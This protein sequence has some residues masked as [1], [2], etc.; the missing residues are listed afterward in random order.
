MEINLLPQVNFSGRSGLS[1]SLGARFTET[2]FVYIFMALA[3]CSG[4][5]SLM[6]VFL[7][8]LKL[9]FKS[10]LSFSCLFQLVFFL[11]TAYV[12]WVLR[13]TSDLRV[14]LH[15]ERLIY[16]IKDRGGMP[17][18][19]KD[20]QT[21]RVGHSHG[22][23]GLFMVLQNNVSYH[24][25]IHLER[26]DYVLDTLH[27]HRPDL[28][29]TKEFMTFRS[30]ALVADH[31]LAH[32]RSYLTRAHVKALSFYLFYPFYVRHSLQRL[33]ADPNQ[34]SRDMNYEKKMET[35]CH[36]LNIGI[37]LAMLAVVVLLKYRA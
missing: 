14:H 1:R 24:F 25:P 15:D 20:I 9:Q 17:F 13:E 22:I 11:V 4:F 27:F 37:S 16:E 18:S 23:Y 19:F 32:N 36:K 28:T 21:I 8:L 10:V 26:L 35:M 31:I 5:F 29:Q 6:N 30:R 12:A 7:P 3:L 2:H 33:K 34:V